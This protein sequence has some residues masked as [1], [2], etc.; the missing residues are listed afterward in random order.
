M[1]R[2]SANAHTGLHNTYAN[3]GD[4]NQQQYGIYQ[5]I[6]WGPGSLPISKID[7]YSH[8]SSSTGLVM[9]CLPGQYGPIVMYVLYERICIQMCTHEHVMNLCKTYTLESKHCE[10][11]QNVRLDW[12]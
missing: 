11:E 5:I 12:L 9:A 1:D 4:N 8:P 10:H 3:R 6:R 7:A 2:A